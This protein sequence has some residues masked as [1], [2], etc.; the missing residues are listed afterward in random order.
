[1][2]HAPK[3]DLEWNGTMAKTNC[4]RSP[5]GFHL[6]PSVFSKLKLKTRFIDSDS[7]WENGTIELFNGKYGDELL[8]G[9]IFETMRSLAPPDL[10]TEGLGVPRR[11]TGA[12]NL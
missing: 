3:S 1:M 9:E 2:F 12:A 11:D 10:P 5:T 8:N 4:Q 7:F 6:G